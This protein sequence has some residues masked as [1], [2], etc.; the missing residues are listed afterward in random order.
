M[1]YNSLLDTE[2]INNKWEFINCKYESGV[3]VSNSKIFGISQELVLPNKSKLYLRTKYRTYNKGI[4][5]V[6]VGIQYGD[7]LSINQRVPDFNKLQQISVIDE[8][9][10]EKVKLHIIFESI[11]DINKVSIY[12]PLLVDLNTV[13]KSTWV[14]CILDKTLSFREGYSFT[15]IYKSGE[16]KPTFED[17]S[18][19]NLE[20]AKIGS[21]INTNSNIDVTLNAKLIENHLYL[22]KLDFE[23]INRFGDIYFQY[24]FL[25]SSKLDNEQSYLIFKADGENNLKLCIDSNDIIN[26]KVNIKHILLIDITRMRILKSDIEYLPFV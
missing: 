8:V 25:K 19:I 1:A 20:D 7:R 17:F 12:E 16:I 2:F 13:G 14:K 5:S 15:N 24:K 4:F 22:A 26:Y 9:K 6:K 3:F 21:I 18:N 10:T 11:E 23:E